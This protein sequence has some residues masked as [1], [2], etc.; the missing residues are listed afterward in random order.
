METALPLDVP[1]VVDV[2]VGD[3]WLDT[4]RWMS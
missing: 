2:S 3:N 1:I 4:Q